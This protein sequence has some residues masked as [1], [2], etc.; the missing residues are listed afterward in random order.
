M[1]VRVGAHGGFSLDPRWVQRS[2]VLLFIDFMRIFGSTVLRV[3]Q[4]H[5]RVDTS[6]D[7]ECDRVPTS[8]TDIG[9][10]RACGCAKCETMDINQE[11]A[12]GVALGHIVAT[13]A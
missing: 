6:H 2:R 5:V 9:L 12:M 8:D 10:T 13:D 7:H 3:E 1:C 11:T 4:I